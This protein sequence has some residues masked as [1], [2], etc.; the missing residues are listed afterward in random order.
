MYTGK[1]L[2]HLDI[3]RS[4]CLANKQL[5]IAQDNLVQ[6]FAFGAP[7]VGGWAP[8][9][10]GWAPPRQRAPTCS[11]LRGSFLVLSSTCTYM[12]LQ[13]SRTGEGGGGYASV[14]QAAGAGDAEDAAQKARRSKR[15][16]AAEGIA[17]A[18]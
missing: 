10:T 2:L 16:G 17:A 3:Q 11:G 14:A 8:P 9:R 1:V 18:L 15:R 13:K 7:G 6:S 12:G 4:E 5:L